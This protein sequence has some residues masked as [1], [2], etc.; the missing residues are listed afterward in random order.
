MWKYSVAIALACLFALNRAEGA[1]PPASI[2]IQATTGAVAPGDDIR[3][4][5]MIT[6]TSADLLRFVHEANILSFGNFLIVG[7]GG[8]QLAPLPLSGGGTS[9]FLDALSPGQEVHETRVLNH[10][11]DMRAPGTYTIQVQKHFGLG[12]PD[13]KILSNIVTITVTK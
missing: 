2:S 7:P 5:V 3:L 4:E 13:I 1:E 10:M 8:A 12:H 9:F 11:F 6:N